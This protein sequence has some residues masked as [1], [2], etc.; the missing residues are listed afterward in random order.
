[1]LPARSGGGGVVEPEDREGQPSAPDVRRPEG[2]GEEVGATPDVLDWSGADLGARA[3]RSRETRERVLSVAVEQL[4]RG[5][6]AAVRIDE[7]NERASVSIGSIYHHFGD[8]DGVIA[9]AQ[10]RRFSRYA[11]AEIASLSEVVREARSR[12]EFRRALLQ[13]AKGSH[14]ALRRDV[15]WGRLAVMASTVGRSDLRDDVADLQTRLTDEF[16]AHVAQGQARGFFRSDL[17]ARAIAAFVEAWTLGIALNDLDG[18]GVPEQLW[19]DVVA[20][21]IDALLAAE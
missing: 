7:I 15:R 9:A 12:A 14:S 19:L 13:L 8:R 21:A 16:Q 10:L 4:E 17:D 1:M 11:E 6:E 5:G 3:E 2:V 18:R 20:V